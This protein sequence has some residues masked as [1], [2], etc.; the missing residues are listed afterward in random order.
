M[1]KK[2][3]IAG[4]LIAWL[5]VAGLFVGA[6]NL[7]QKQRIEKQKT[8]EGLAEYPLEQHLPDHSFKL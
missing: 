3:F 7:H 8:A 4:G 1:N 5:V 6:S 2:G